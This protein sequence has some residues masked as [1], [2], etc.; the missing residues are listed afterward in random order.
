[1]S[2]ARRGRQ[3]AQCLGHAAIDALP[4]KAGATLEEDQRIR[5]HGLGADRQVWI[6]QAPLAADVLEHREVDHAAFF[7]RVHGNA[8]GP[9]LRTSRRPAAP[10]AAPTGQPAPRTIGRASRSKAE[11]SLIAVAVG[12]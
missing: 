11:K 8:V 9:V 1:M 7:E 6:R 12:P 4:E 10:M 2:V 3:R 5:Q